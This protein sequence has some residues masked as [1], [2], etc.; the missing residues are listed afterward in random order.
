MTNLCCKEHDV[1]WQ[2]STSEFSH[3]RRNKGGKVVETKMSNVRETSQSFSCI[4]YSKQVYQQT[5][6]FALLYDVHKSTNSEFPSWNFEKFYLD[7]KKKH[8]MHG[9]VS[10]L[11][12]GHLWTCWADA[13]TWRESYLKWFRSLDTCIM[14]VS[15]A[16]W[17]P[18]QIWRFGF[19]YFARPIHT[20]MEMIYGRLHHLLLRYNHNFEKGRANWW[21]CC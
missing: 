8:W 13:A 18:F 12:R 4:R 14:L 6:E 19:F 2:Y 21:C 1:F 20:V 10:F 7:E 9:W 5:T 15:Q 11:R 17:L 3:C 16:L